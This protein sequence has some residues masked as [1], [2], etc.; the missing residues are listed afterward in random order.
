MPVGYLVTVLLVAVCTTAALAPRGGPSYRRYLLALVVNEVP[1]LA[2][3]WLAAA[4]W[5]AFRSG[6]VSSPAAWAV[7]GLAAATG[8]GLA[9]VAARGFRAGVVVR[10]ALD[11]DLGPRLPDAQG[12]AGV[13]PRPWVRLRRWVRLATTLVA[14]VV[15]GHRGVVRVRNLSYGDAG[16]RNL[17]DLYRPRSGGPGGLDG[18]DGP[19]G[20]TLVYLHGGS[21]RRG[22]K[23]REARA[24]LY[25]LA[26]QG[27]VCVSATY[28][29]SPAATFPDHVVDVKKVIAWVRTE[30]QRYGARPVVV[31]AGSSAGA[32]L[33]ALAALTPGHPAF[34]PGFEDADTSVSAA[35]CLYGYYGSVGGSRGAPSSPGA[36]VHPGAPPFF[37]AHGDRDSLITVDHARA[38]VARL[39]AASDAPVVYA[40]LPGGQHGFD[41]FRSVRFEAVVDGV[42]AF[43]ATVLP[44]ARRAAPGTVSRRPGRRT[45]T[46]P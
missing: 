36:Y 7:V 12:R 19:G 41:V 34:Q 44:D 20:P 24:L 18:P 43:V 17:L 5:L 45:P 13:G 31:V 9:V 37:V 10:R 46:G 40:E 29:L 26:R 28:R 3:L 33:A 8:M 21:F 38:F 42:E 14:P 22:R 30:G 35:V 25:R 32:H 15:V 23:S 16:E 6:D 4:T 2:L 1:G 11:A 27:W 39:R